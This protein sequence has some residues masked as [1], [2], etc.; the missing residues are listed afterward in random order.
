MNLTRTI[1]AFSTLIGIIS[2]IIKF[3]LEAKWVMYK[4]PV[5]F[6]KTLVK[7]QVELG[8]VNEEDLTENFF[9]KET[10]A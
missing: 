6:Y 4:N 7:K 9:I 2:I 5:A 3:W 10:P 8:I 1:V